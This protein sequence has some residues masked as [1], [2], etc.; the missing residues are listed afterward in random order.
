MLAPDIYLNFPMTEA[1]ELVAEATLYLDGNG[2]GAANTGTGIAASLG[3]R[4]GGIAP[5]VAYDYFE[6]SDCFDT[7]IPLT[8]AQRQTCDAANSRNFK[9]GLNFFFAKNTNHLNVEFQVNHGLSG[10]GPNNITGTAGYTPLS[11]DPA[12]ATGPRR[13]FNANLRNQAFKSVLV[14][15]NVIF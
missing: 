4:F 8:A 15:W 5:Y 13:A 11:L 7:S 1:A 6:A 2:T 9:A 12:T 14:H 10:Y 3:Y